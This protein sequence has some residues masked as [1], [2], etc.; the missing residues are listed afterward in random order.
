M[1]DL[2]ACAIIIVVLCA[3]GIFAY[4]II[5]DKIESRNMFNAMKRMAKE[6]SDEYIKK[7]Y[8]EIE[9]KEMED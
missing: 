4:I 2:I 6:E 5:S 7:L 3:V 9:G 1:A 8:K